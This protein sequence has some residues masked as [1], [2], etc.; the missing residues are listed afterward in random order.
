MKIVFFLLYL[1]LLNGYI[2]NITGE[3][4]IEYSDIYCPDAKCIWHGKP[5]QGN[6]QFHKRY[7]A[8]KRTLLKCAACGR[9]FSERIGTIF[10]N[11]KHKEQTIIQVFQCLCEGNSLS[12][13]ERITKVTRKTVS[14]WLKAAASHVEEVSDYLLNNLHFSEIQLDEF[15]SFVK[16]K[17]NHLTECEKLEGE[18]GNC[19]GHISFDPNTKLIPAHI[20][21]KRTKE[22]VPSL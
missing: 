10:Y 9:I 13:V 12:E 19:W 5:G 18:Y 15:W 17:Q 20:F 1:L 11:R 7:G 14:T 21:G 6:I 2:Q 8:V 4:P 22:N 3:R 16:K